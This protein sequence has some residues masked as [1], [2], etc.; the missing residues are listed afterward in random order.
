MAVASLKK[1]K[2][3]KVQPLSY[4]QKWRAE[5]KEEHGVSPV[6]MWRRQNPEANQKHREQEKA[7]WWS[8][9]TVRERHR[10]RGRVTRLALKLEVYEA[11]G[12]AV[13]ACCGESELLFLSLDHEHND[14][15]AERKE[16]RTTGG[17]CFYRHLKK[18]GFPPG[19]QV[20]CM[21]CNFGK[22]MNDGVCPH[23]LAGG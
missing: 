4:F 21:N 8:D 13:C 11:Y 17:A 5:F 1:V 2:K 3:K 6:T 14:G 16:L 22:R 20:L 18:R 10:E 9:P 12:G 15:A 19:Y 23:R 7:R